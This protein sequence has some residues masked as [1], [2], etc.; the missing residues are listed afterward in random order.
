MSAAADENGKIK[1]F[2]FRFKKSKKSQWTNSSLQIKARNAFRHQ[3][4]FQN[5]L[6]LS[7]RLALENFAEFNQDGLRDVSR[8]GVLT[9]WFNHRR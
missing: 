5:C 4:H 7:W 9:W 2:L 1:H 3:V 8:Q 6:F